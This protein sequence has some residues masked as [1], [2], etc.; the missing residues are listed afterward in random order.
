MKQ[1]ALLV[2]DLQRGAFDGERI[3][4]I[5]DAPRL[6]GNALALINAAR[7]NSVPVIFVQ[8]CEGAGEIFEEGSPRWELHEALKPRPTEK[9]VR[10]RAESAFEKTD[11]E[12]TLRDLD[13]EQLVLCGLQSEFCVR[14]TAKSALKLGFRVLVVSDGHRTWPAEKESAAAIS[15]R[16]NNELEAAGARLNSTAEIVGAM[17]QSE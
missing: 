10:K 6:I 12:G 13:I 11:L 9:L 5:S 8:H 4:V 2:I 14:S 15:A 7:K 3:G 17:S 16:V 1:T